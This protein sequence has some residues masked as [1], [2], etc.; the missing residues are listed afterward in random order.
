MYHVSSGET[1]ELYKIDFLINSIHIVMGID[2]G[3]SISVTKYDTYLKLSCKSTIL[4][5]ATNVIS[6]V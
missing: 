4:F 1:L 2:T 5:V 3:A 6:F